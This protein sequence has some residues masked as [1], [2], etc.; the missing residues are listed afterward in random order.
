MMC[1][2]NCSQYQAKKEPRTKF[3]VL[4]VSTSLGVPPAVFKPFEPWIFLSISN[5]VELKTLY[6]K[7]GPSKHWVLAWLAIPSC[8][9]M[10]NENC[11]CF[12]KAFE[13]KHLGLGALNIDDNH[14]Y[15]R[16][17]RNPDLDLGF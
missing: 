6:A 13:I 1:N 16:G 7:T 2:D 15:L 11:S 9:V 10:S 5:Q 8:G 3:S 17:K 14:Y 12:G 4:R